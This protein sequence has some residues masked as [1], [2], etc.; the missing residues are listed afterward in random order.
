MTI[1]DIIR[2]VLTRSNHGLPL[3]LITAETSF[4]EIKY[5]FSSTFW[6]GVRGLSRNW[7]KLFVTVWIIV[8]G[9]I[10]ALAG[11][12]AAVLVL[13]TFRPAWPAGAA[14]FHAIGNS[15][16]LF[17]LTLDNGE[18]GGPLCRSPSTSNLQSPVSDYLGCP[19]AGYSTL[20]SVYT[21]WGTDLFVHPH[22]PI[23]FYEW[24]QPRQIFLQIRAPG[25]A[26]ESWATGTQPAINIWSG[27]LHIAWRG[28]ISIIK[29]PSPAANF[30]FGSGS[31]TH[32][33]TRI[34]A[35]RTVCHNQNSSDH[36]TNRSVSVSYVRVFN[37]N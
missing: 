10:V 1:R 36:A 21:Q 19:W 27:S 33:P 35:V 25:N 7:Q 16:T 37:R 12:S 28:A 29:S 15:S 32:I 2:F 22:N 34:P 8:S 13:P 4:T 6:S 17:P 24:Q 9:I 3:G 5:F 11:P 14:Y 26:P 31:T 23:N 20:M 30:K 18:D